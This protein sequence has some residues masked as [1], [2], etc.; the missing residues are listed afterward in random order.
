MLSSLGK[1]TCFQYHVFAQ[2]MTESP[3]RKVD[4]LQKQME[5]REM[6]FILEK[7]RVRALL[8]AVSLQKEVLN[9]KTDGPKG[10]GDKSIEKSFIEEQLRRAAA[11]EVKKEKRE[12]EN[13]VFKALT[14]EQAIAARVS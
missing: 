13:A 9:D 12:R 11:S 3:K 7:L 8:K 1:Q 14:R 10:D 6:D 4:T 2:E 5:R